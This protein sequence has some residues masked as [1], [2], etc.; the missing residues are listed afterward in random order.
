MVGSGATFDFFSGRIKQ[1]P[2][3]IREA[4]F[5]WLY[6]LTKDFRRLWVRYLDYNLIFVVMFTLHL[7]GFAHTIQVRKRTQFD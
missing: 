6:R 1:A 2:A 4:G 3:W 7:T 5:E